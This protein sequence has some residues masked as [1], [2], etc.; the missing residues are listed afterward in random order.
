MKTIDKIANASIGTSLVG[1]AT[2]TFSIFPTMNKTSFYVGLGLAGT[3]IAG[4][5]ATNIIGTIK[6][7][8][9]DYPIKEKYSIDEE[10]NKGLVEGY[11]G[12]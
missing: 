6:L 3:G 1:I 8:K 10:L 2:S 9:G 11:Y 4:L 7:L 12:A 5:L